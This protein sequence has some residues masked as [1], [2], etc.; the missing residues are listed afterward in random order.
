MSKFVMALDQGTT[1]SRCILF[2]KEGLIESSAQKE[3]DQIYPNAGWVEHNPIE[4]W[5]SQFSVAIEAMAKVGA[6]ASDIAAIGITNQRETTIVW[7]KRTGLPVY[8][9]IVWQCRRTANMCDD[10]KAKGFD[11]VVKE[12]TGLILDAYF[13][14]TKVKWILDNVEGAREN[15]EKGN[16]LFGNVDAW[17][18]WNLTKGKTYVTDYSNA[19]RTMLFNIHELKWDAEILKELNIPLCMLPEVKPSSCVYG[20]T[21]ATLFGAEIPIAGAAGDQQAA[22]FGQCCF[23]PG[24]A[25]NTYGTGAFL[26]MNTGEKAVE[27]KNG[28][29][30]TIA[31]GAEG[32]VEYALE[33]SVFIAGAAIQWLRDELR[34]IDNAADS[35]RYATAVE[36]T[37]G[38]YMVPAFVGLGAPYWDQYARGAIVGLTRGAKKEHLIRAT[39]E[40]IAYQTNDVLKAMQEDS[41]IE[42]KALKVDG[43]ACANNFLMQFQA[44]VLGVQVDRPEIIETTALGAAYLAGLAVGYWKDKEDIRS[45]WALSRAFKANMEVEKREELLKGWHKA[46]GRSQ[47]WAE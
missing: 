17:L 21:D 19:S 35:E 11:K 28:L 5:S 30:T 22:L 42:L 18:I 23:E 12:K 25:K 9:A 45:N 46:V 10:L 3:F 37:N 2:N 27:S 41:G 47:D 32:K 29:L 14:G 1:S 31:W 40:S 20:N 38:V 36:D 16:L 43:G 24:T 4:I 13:S 7:D 6:E 15:A 8:N 33:G 39:L 34:M 44:D 26:L